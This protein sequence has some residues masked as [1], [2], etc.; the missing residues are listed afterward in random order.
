M[1]EAASVG[2]QPHIVIDYTPREL[3]AAMLGGHMAQSRD[4]KLALWHAWTN[5]NFTRAKKL[6]DLAPLLRK[7]DPSPVKMTAKAIRTAIFAMAS[8]MG[9]K[10]TR[11][12]KQRKD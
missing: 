2:I 9:A 1:A 12:K 5:A 4:Q 3:Y 6:P 7:L 8:A 10:V 11:I